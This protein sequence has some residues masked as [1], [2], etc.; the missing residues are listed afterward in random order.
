MTYFYFY[1][2]N[3]TGVIAINTPSDFKHDGIQLSMEGAVNL[4]LSS[5]N[6][7]ILEA[8]YNAVKVGL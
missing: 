8:F 1:Q 2:E 3:V 7:G 5:K 6:V 4:Q